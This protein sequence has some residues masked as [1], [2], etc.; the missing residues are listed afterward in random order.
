MIY[1]L[2]RKF[3]LISGL[4]LVAVFGLMFAAICVMNLITT[5]QE[6][7]A[8]T[9]AIADHDGMFPS[10]EPQRPFLNESRGMPDAGRAE[11]FDREGPFD[12]RYFTVWFDEAGE[13]ADAD[14]ESISSVAQEEAFQYAE[15]AAAAGDETGWMS[16]FRYRVFQTAVGE[17]VVFVDA[18]MNLAMAY[19]IIVSVGVVLLGSG[20]IILLLIVIF[21]RR[22]VTPVAESYEKQKQFITDANH[23]LKTPLTLILTNLDIAESQVGKNEWLEDIRAEGERMAQLV[24]QLVTLTRMDEEGQQPEAAEFSLSEAVSDT[25]SEFRCLAESEGKHLAVAVEPCISFTGN[26][27][28][29]RK[30]LS[31]LMDNAVKYCDEGGDIRVSFGQKRHPVLR[32]ENTCQDVGNIE[33]NRLFDRFYRADKS[34]TYMGGFGIGLSIAKAVAAKQNSEISAY[35][36]GEDWI[37]FKVVFKKR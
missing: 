16:G 21:S 13:A 28:A 36:K 6:L 18:G 4:S 35:R 11:P 14:L 15:K 1:R 3:I 24:N 27:E 37:G 22:A 30:L 9:E 25:V 33:L 12:T 32:V 5:R 2:Q 20:L 7:D 23:E 26:E 29:V 8:L 10:G 19:R 17:A 34:R 31:I